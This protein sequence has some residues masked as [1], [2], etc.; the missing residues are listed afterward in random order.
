MNTKPRIIDVDASN[1]LE[2]VEELNDFCVL[3]DANLLGRTA[4][5]LNNKHIKVVED[6]DHY[7]FDCVGVWDIDTLKSFLNL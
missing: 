2:V 5:I 7:D 6:T 1:L 3:A 4:F